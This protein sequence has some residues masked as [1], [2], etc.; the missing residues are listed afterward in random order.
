[1]SKE[2]IMKVLDESKEK[3]NLIQ[4]GIKD[5]CNYESTKD[6]IYPN[7]ERDERND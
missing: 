1:M 7:E 4:E 2:E 5:N 3:F 6:L